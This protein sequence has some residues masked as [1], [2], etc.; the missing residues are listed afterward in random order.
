MRAFREKRERNIFQCYFTPSLNPNHWDG[1]SVTPLSHPHPSQFLPLAYKHMDPPP[2]LFLLF[3]KHLILQKFKFP[4]Q[5]H[6]LH[7]TNQEGITQTFWVSTSQNNPGKRG[8]ILQKNQTEID[9]FHLCTTTFPAI[10]Q[11]S[12]SMPEVFSPL[13]TLCSELSW[14]F[15]SSMRTIFPFILIYLPAFKFCCFPSASLL[16]S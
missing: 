3:L 9:K 8:H 2:L 15:P 1:A 12:P 14:I 6:L 10:S 11:L 5:R 13:I 16:K 4:A 7:C